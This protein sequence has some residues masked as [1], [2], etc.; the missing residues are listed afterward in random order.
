MRMIPVASSDLAAVGY[1]SGALYVSFHSG[2]TYRY[3]GVP[4]S[5]Y[6]ELMAAPSHGRYFHQ[7]I[8]NSFPYQKVG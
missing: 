3:A 8:R 1:E 7:F 4:E 5:V 6:R 2:G